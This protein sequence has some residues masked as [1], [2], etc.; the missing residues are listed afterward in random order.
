M[1]HILHTHG[2]NA[3][4]DGSDAGLSLTKFS[5]NDVSSEMKDDSICNLYVNDFLTFR[6]K[7]FD[8]SLYADTLVKDL[9][10]LEKACRSNLQF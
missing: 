6:V 7:I 4:V 5:R 3:L 2:G 10:E 9:F 1:W 8:V